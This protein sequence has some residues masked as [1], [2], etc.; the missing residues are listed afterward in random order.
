VQK[1]A[2]NGNSNCSSNS[3]CSCHTALPQLTIHM[4]AGFR[5]PEGEQIISN[6]LWQMS[7]WHQ[8]QQQQQQQQQ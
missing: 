5:F 8:Q 1:Q 2:S 7:A 6:E 4:S 3:K